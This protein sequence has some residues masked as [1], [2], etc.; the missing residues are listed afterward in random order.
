MHPTITPESGRIPCISGRRIANAGSELQPRHQRKTLAP[1]FYLDDLTRQPFPEM[2]G[3]V[4][5]YYKVT[6]EQIREG[7]VRKYCL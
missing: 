2:R 1:L 4:C 5:K 6:C 3:H 7:E